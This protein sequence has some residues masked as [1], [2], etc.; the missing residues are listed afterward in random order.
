[1]REKIGQAKQP[2]LDSGFQVHGFIKIIIG[3][4][5]VVDNSLLIFY[6]VLL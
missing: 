5:V 2:R 4:H 6:F 1:M 3:S